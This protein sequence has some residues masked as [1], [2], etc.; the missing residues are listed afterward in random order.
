MSRCLARPARERCG[1]RAGASGTIARKSPSGSLLREWQDCSASGASMGAGKQSRTTTGGAELLRE[2]RGHG[3]LTVSDWLTGS[4]RY[5]FSAGI[6]AWGSLRAAS[7]RRH[8]LERRWF[9]DRLAMAVMASDW[10]PFPNS[11]QASSFNAVGARVRVASRPDFSGWRYQ[12]TAGIDRVSDN[13]PLTLWPGAGEGWARTP[14]LRAHPLLDDGA[15]DVSGRTVFG[16]SV[17]YANAEAQRWLER[18]AMV[19]LGLAGFVDIAQASRPMNIDTTGRAQADIGAGLRLRFPATR[20]SFESTSRTGFGTAP[21]HS[22]SGGLTD[23]LR[24]I[25]NARMQSVSCISAFL[26][27]CIFLK[28]DEGGSVTSRRRCASRGVRIWRCITPRWRQSIAT[29][30]R[31]R[32]SCWRIF[33]RRGRSS[34]SRSA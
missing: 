30:S 26:H 9:D 19:R 3:A 6:D 22:A 27:S 20:A 32:R 8:R 24:V 1:R 25:D 5:S 29:G 11:V 18:P 28:S 16:R 33:K 2:T 31:A 13:A 10:L 23:A 21:T 4:V 7:R 14:L 17:R 12:A 34:R 15:I